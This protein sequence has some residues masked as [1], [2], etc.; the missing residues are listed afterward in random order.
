M[1][2]EN[3]MADTTIRVFTIADYF[4]LERMGDMV[5]NMFIDELR[6]LAKRI[7]AK[8]NRYG[9]GISDSFIANFFEAAA[10][11][12]SSTLPSIGNL[13]KAFLRFF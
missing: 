6:L 13:Q 2:G 1:A 12:Y 4:G 5:A 9:H 11:V 10:K 7:H 3:T 8:R